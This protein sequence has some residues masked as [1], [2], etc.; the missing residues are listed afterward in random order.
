M[1]TQQSR[2]NRVNGNIYPV[3]TDSVNVW[4]PMKTRKYLSGLFLAFSTY[5]FIQSTFF[6]GSIAHYLYFLFPPKEN[7][8]PLSFSPYHLI[9][10]CNWV[11][12]IGIV[13]SCIFFFMAA[14]PFTTQWFK[15]RRWV[16]FPLTV[17]AT[18][19]YFI[20]LYIVCFCVKVVFA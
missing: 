10:Y 8:I 3:S 5:C 14:L 4:S 11:I 1:S 13:L 17:L 2:N 9:P 18:P 7:G 12:G 16:S 15:D 6:F 19:F 20:M